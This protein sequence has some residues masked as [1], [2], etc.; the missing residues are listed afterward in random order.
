MTVL[1]SKIGEADA[2]TEGLVE[3]R[4][5]RAAAEAS[6]ALAFKNVSAGKAARPGVRQGW[7]HKRHAVSRLGHRD[8]NV[9]T[10]SKVDG[11]FAVELPVVSAEE[12]KILDA[13]SVDL[14]DVNIPIGGCAAIK[15][16]KA[17]AGVSVFRSAGGA[18]GEVELAGTAGQNTQVELRGAKFAAKPETVT[19]LLPRDA[20]SY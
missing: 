10:Q 19:A 8:G 13:P 12:G 2:R 4:L 11:K 14:G 20:S 6:G 5:W 15:A 18:L 7:V 3:G 1:G 9:I 16:G 17:K